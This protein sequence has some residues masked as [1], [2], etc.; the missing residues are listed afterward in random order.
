METAAAAPSECQIIAAAAAAAFFWKR[1]VLLCDLASVVVRIDVGHCRCASVG[2][3]VRRQVRSGTPHLTIDSPFFSYSRMVG[4]N[5]HCTCPL[6]LYDIY[7]DIH[8]VFVL[9]A[10]VTYV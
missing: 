1:V 7:L 5:R 9:V 2:L 3:G 8:E 10:V 6:S 4:W